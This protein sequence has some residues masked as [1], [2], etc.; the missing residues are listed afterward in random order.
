MI[1]MVQRSFFLEA[2]TQCIS[3]E[4]NRQNSHVQTEL[5]RRQMFYI[6]L[7]FELVW[8]LS[9]SAAS[10]GVC[11]IAQNSLPLMIDRLPERCSSAIKTMRY[12]CTCGRYTFRRTQMINI[13]LIGGSDVE[14]HMGYRVRPWYNVLYWN[15]SVR[16]NIL[17]TAYAC[18]F[19]HLA[20][21]FTTVTITI[22]EEKIICY[23]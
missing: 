18:R 15:E 23:S 9:Q 3:I 17:D 8:S 16:V 2:F 21:L 7:R 20:W 19:G 11:D 1:L 13:F 5:V 10:P 6:I 14:S 22:L 12:A 4:D